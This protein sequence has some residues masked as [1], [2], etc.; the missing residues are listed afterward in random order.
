LTFGFFFDTLNFEGGPPEDGLK[1]GKKKPNSLLYLSDQEMGFRISG[2]EKFY[3]KVKERR[4]LFQDE[5]I[6][7][8]LDNPN[9]QLETRR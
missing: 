4:P 8:L 7:L 2:I 9:T 6:V 3:E 5:M 1:D